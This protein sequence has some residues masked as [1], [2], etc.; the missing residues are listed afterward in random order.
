VVARARFPLEGMER[1]AA[2][3]RLPNAASGQD[4]PGSDKSGRE[5]RL[6]RMRS[7]SQVEKM[8]SI[9]VF[10]LAAALAGP[11]MLAGA[12]GAQNPP[13]PL[14]KRIEAALANE[15][16][17]AAI[18]Q[19]TSEG[20]KVS[21][22]VVDAAGNPVYVYVPD[23]VRNGTGDIAIRK[24]LTMTITGKP[25][26]ETRGLIES[27]AAVKAKVEANPRSILFP[28]GVPLMAGSELAGA[29]A[30]SGAT[31]AQDEACA[32]V[33]AGKIASRIK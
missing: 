6:T 14:P 4:V 33:G 24:G 31:G 13:A 21:A 25:A 18:A 12:A 26:S 17:E 10:S 20:L 30:V 8:K 2:P 22:A 7:L 16:V 23:G 11:V 29:I 27:D 1:R 32:K 9:A 19:C 3:E 28:G 15:A 5:S